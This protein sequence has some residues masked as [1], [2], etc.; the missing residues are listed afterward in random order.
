M[1]KIVI[2][3]VP[4]AIAEDFAFKIVESKLAGCINVFPVMQSIYYWQGKIEKEPERMLFI[5]T[6]DSVLDS[7][8]SF[9]QKNHPYQV[10]EIAVLDVSQINDSYLNWLKAYV[11]EDRSSYK[12][13]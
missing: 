11:E 1:V 9:I 8:L 13:L 3:N 7:L 12:T 2:T 4:E 6:T 10:P 5:K